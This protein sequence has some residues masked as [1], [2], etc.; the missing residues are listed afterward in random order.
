MLALTDDF[1]DRAA[2]PHR[3]ELRERRGRV[4][5]CW[6]R[7]A[8]HFECLAFQF[9]VAQT[10]RGGEWGSEHTFVRLAWVGFGSRP[11]LVSPTTERRDSEGGNAS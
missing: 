1:A 8:E 2:F 6:R 11:S 10:K 9:F 4:A 5:R 3:P 7:R